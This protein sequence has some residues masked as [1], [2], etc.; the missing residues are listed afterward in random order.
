[1]SA[2]QSRK[3][4]RVEEIKAAYIAAAKRDDEQTEKEFSDAVQCFY[5]ASSVMKENLHIL[6]ELHQAVQS[7]EVK[8]KSS[9]S[10]RNSRMG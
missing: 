5:I 1:L 8:D 10:K 7:M 2:Q 3:A 4:K 6:K 9:T